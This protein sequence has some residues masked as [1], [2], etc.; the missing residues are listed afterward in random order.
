MHAL[1]VNDGTTGDMHP[2]FALGLCHPERSEGSG[3]APSPSA[4]AGSFA[5]PQPAAK[6]S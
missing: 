4:A 3:R 2:F 1:L 6:A 5:A